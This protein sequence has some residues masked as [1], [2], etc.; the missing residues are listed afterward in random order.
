MLRFLIISLLL[1]TSSTLAQTGQLPDFAGLVEKH[2]AAV[3]NISAVQNS[4]TVSNQM[5]PEMPGIPE[6]SPFYDFFKRHMQP[7]PA[8]R[9][10][11]PKS[12]GSGF[13]ISSDGYILTNAHVIETADEI[14]VKLNDK[15]EFAAEVIGTDRK[16]DIALIKI[17]ASDLPKVTQGNPENLKVGEWVVA[18]GSPFGFEHSVTAGIV[19]AKGR[20]LAQESY[21]PFIQTDVAINPGNS[22]GPLFNMRGE[23]VGINS[24]IYSRTGGF[25]GLS[26]AIPINVATEIAN[27]LK[28]SGKVSRGRIGVMIQEVT[29]ELAE[30]FGLSDSTGALVV[31][32]EKGGPADQAGIKPRDIILKFDEKEVATSADLPRIVGNTKPKSKVSIEVW[33]DGTV[34]TVKVEVGETPSDETAENRKHK[35][36]KKQNASNRLGLALSEITEEQQKQLEIISGLLVEDMQ[37]GIASR[38]GIRIGDIIL[39]LNSKDVK[40]VEQFNE[41]L[42]QVKSGK[43]I[44]LLVKRGDVTTFITM[45]LSDDDKK[46]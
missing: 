29:K 31:S 9:K 38:S 37:T 1:Y 26:F 6:N 5:L 3:V 21:V 22:G 32:V 8:P 40:T 41:L 35:P 19:S 17:N 39:G 34:K 30:S 7:F 16:T 43:N 33:R 20:S 14:T 10:S 13:I 15:R 45:K 27:Q 44:A 11:E 18:I 25:M 2:G 12:L 28:V 46:E 24:Q 23:V 42:N 4:N 36:G